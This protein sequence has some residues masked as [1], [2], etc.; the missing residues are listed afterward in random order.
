MAEVLEVI[1][2]RRPAR[3]RWSLSGPDAYP[4]EAACRPRTDA[5]KR[6]VRTVGLL[7]RSGRKGLGGA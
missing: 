3:G 2:L 7:L 6:A 4:Y 5:D 1:E